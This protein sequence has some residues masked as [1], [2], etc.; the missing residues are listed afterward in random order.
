MRPQACPILIPLF[1][2][3]ALFFEFLFWQ[4]TI[5]AILILNA[6]LYKLPGNSIAVEI[7]SVVGTLAVS[8]RFAEAPHCCSCIDASGFATDGR[9][10]SDQIPRSGCS[11][12]QMKL[13]VA[14]SSWMGCKCPKPCL[15]V[16]D[17]F[18]HSLTVADSG[19]HI[20][21]QESLRLPDESIVV[22]K[23]VRYC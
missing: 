23:L 22:L 18:S 13:R 4:L 10:C 6:A 1:T 8:T 19:L 15:F 5:P 7:S 9:A 12:N 3:P 11:L 21:I 20:H 14:R 2:L 17:T 16:F